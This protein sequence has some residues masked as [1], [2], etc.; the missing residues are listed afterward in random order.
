MTTQDST[1]EKKKK[2]RAS[3]SHVKQKAVQDI[4]ELIDRYPVVAIINLE[5]LP[6]RQL[7]KMK[8]KL[9]KDIEIKVTKKSIIQHAL[10][11]SNKKDITRLSKYL[12]GSPALLLSK[13]NPFKIYKLLKQSK[14]AAAIKAGQATPKD[15]VIPAG[16]T[17]FAPGPIIGELGMMKIKAGIE[18]GKIVIKDDAHVAKKG[19]IIND[20]LASLLL[21][22][23]IEPMEIGLNLVAAYENGD[24]LTSEVLD[25]DDKI[26]I[27]KIQTAASEAMNLAVDIAYASN[28]TIILLIQK[29]FRDSKAIAIDRDILADGVLEQILAK[30]DAQAAAVSEI[31]NK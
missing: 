18:A 6:T 8:T 12:I 5:N 1:K 14:S 27:Q 15:L 22:L 25:I 29:S 17:P 16:P 30:A 2:G 9:R 26:F 3:V 7:Q 19:D 23:G 13:E 20:K 11:I 21:R 4:K 28:D 10:E 31:V 24:I